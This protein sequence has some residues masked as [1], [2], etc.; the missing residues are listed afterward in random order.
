VKISTF[1]LTSLVLTA[2]APY[3]LHSARAETNAPA[4]EGQAVVASPPVS[5]FLA[6]GS[7]EAADLAEL[8]KT[9]GEVPGV[10]KVETRP[11][12]SLIVIRIEGDVVPPPLNAAAQA[13]GYR[14]RA[15]SPQFY[16]VAGPNDEASV[17]RLKDA[18]TPVLGLS[19][20]SLQR[21]TAGV[22][23]RIVGPVPYEALVAAGKAAGFTVQAI[24]SY[25]ASGPSDAANLGKL[26]T[27]LSGA[28]G[29]E[30]LE[31]RNLTGGATLLVYGPARQPAVVAAGKSAGYLVWQLANGQ[32]RREFRVEGP[33]QPADRQ[34]LS[35]ALL[36]VEGI[37]N[38]EFIGEPGD[39]RVQ[40]G[41]T[42]PQL[43]AVLAAGSRAGFRLTPLDSFALPSIEPASGRNTPPDPSQR[44]PAEIAQ[45]GAVPPT[46][47]LLDKDGVT[48][49]KLTDLM[50]QKKP[51][52]LLFGSCT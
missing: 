2:G 16:M 40:V 27:A 5:V 21:T 6:M 4:R 20:L 26:R 52:V 15:A 30:K 38:T 33:S 23:A 48:P 7:T 29:V 51:V 34:R 13:A 28:P 22:G 9:L 17:R 43:Q 1:I 35:E 49:V 47:E 32:S 12:G 24:E 42:Q 39:L 45:V 46:F 11:D 19:I 25:V 10:S 3:G 18:L 44:G 41:G 36:R 14:M 37:A 31:M 50:A 8:R